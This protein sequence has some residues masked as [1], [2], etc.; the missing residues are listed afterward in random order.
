[1]SDYITFQSQQKDV[2]KRE[3]N[4]RWDAWSEIIDNGIDN[5]NE[6]LFG[7]LDDNDDEK[8]CVPP[9]FD[10]KLSKQEIRNITEFIHKWDGLKVDVSKRPKYYQDFKNKAQSWMFGRRAVQ[11]GRNLY[12]VMLNKAHRVIVINPC[13]C[14]DHILHIMNIVHSL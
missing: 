7:G 4:L 9:K 12:P 1:M 10:R 11:Y 6:K 3:T 5:I 13:M 8:K 14:I 2:C